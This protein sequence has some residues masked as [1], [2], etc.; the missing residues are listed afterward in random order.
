MSAPA[1][2]AP[3]TSPVEAVRPPIAPALGTAEP[4]RTVYRPNGPLDVHSTLRLIARGGDGPCYRRVPG[5]VWLT[6]RTPLG[7]GTLHVSTVRDGE[8]E[9]TAWG[10][11]AEWMIDGVPE[12]LGRDDDWSDLDVSRSPLL[13][14]VSRRNPG[15]RLSRNRLVFEM[16]VPSILEQKVT[17]LEAWRAWRLLVRRHG[18][19][20]PGPALRA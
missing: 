13:T 15:L 8:V 5:G 9:A 12:L 17:A 4:L 19:P 18:D 14:E 1:S 6:A 2:F 11:G 20:A 3:P 7:G 16:L 10:P